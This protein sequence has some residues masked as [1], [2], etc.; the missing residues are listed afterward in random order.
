MEYKEYKSK[1][2]NQQTFIEQIEIARKENNITLKSFDPSDSNFGPWIPFNL[3]REYVDFLIENKK[4]HEAKETLIK[5][6]NSYE[7][8]SYQNFIEIYEYR[9]DA[10]LHSNKNLKN[11]IIEAKKEFNQHAILIISMVV[12]IV[13]IFGAA[14][15]TIQKVDYNVALANFF[16]VVLA[17]GFLTFIAFFANSFFNKK[18]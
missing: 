3:E 13:T 8:G 17:V 15:V 7:G 16:A 5:M 11:E 2:Y 1:I 9:L 14:N 18:K 6:R 4:Y 10:I 12:G